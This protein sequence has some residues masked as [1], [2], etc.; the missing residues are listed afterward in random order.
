MRSPTINAVAL[1][2]GVSVASVSRVMNGFSARPETELRVRAAIADLGYQPNSA[3][4]ALKVRESDQICLSFAD[5]GNPAYVSMTRG[6]GRILHESKYRLLLASSFSTV[7]EIIK[8]LES[9]GRGYADGLIISPI[10]SDPEITELISQLKMPVVLIGT[11]PDGL[12]V[13]NVHVDSS[14][15]IKL[16]VTHLKLRGRSKIGLLNGPLSTN[17]GRRRDE[18]FKKVLK[19]LKL[20]FK[21]DHIIQAEDFTSQSA[22]DAISHYEKLSEIDALICGNDLMAAGALRYL[23]EENIEV[24]AKIAVV[25]IDNTELASLVKP[26]LTSVDLLAEKRGEL[27]AKLLLD[28]IANPKR[29]PK[30]IV[31]EPELIVRGSS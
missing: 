18:G 7:G 19:N 30:T 20:S 26:T 24:P 3:A 14:L 1:Q 22:Y 4:R 28:R 29:A 11:M 15:G 27:A 2:A 23:S 5:I 31:V 8:Q 13:D 16:A 17:P 6:V 21:E 10:Y 9:M 25:G 12:E